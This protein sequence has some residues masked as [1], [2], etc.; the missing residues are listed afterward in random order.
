MPQSVGDIT[1]ER[2]F[3]GLFY[4][5]KQLTHRYISPVSYRS[6]EYNTPQYKKNRT[7]SWRTGT[8]LTQTKTYKLDE[9]HN[10][11]NN[12]SGKAFGNITVELNE[13]LIKFI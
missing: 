10:N 13:G 8:H 11:S 2:L 5:D 3:Q 9:K 12:S 4:S 6:R 1:L 7:L